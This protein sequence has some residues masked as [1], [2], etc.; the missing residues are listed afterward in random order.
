MGDNSL[1]MTEIYRVLKPGG[2]V[3]IVDSL[4]NNLIYRFNRYLHYYKENRTKST[5]KRVPDINLINKYIKKFGHGKTWFFGSITWTFPL[6]KIVLS[7][8]MITNFSNWID[9]KFNVRKSAFK[10][11]L[12]LNKNK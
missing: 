9:N 10:F 1:V 5:L 12:I 11:V 7:E 3:I 2:T 6:L 4:N 8:K